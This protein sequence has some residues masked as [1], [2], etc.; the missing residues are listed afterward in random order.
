MRIP[1]GFSLGWMDGV[2]GDAY[3]ARL[4]SPAARARRTL[5]YARAN[6]Q[7]HCAA[8]YKDATVVALRLPGSAC[9]S[10]L[11]HVIVR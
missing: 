1:L 9:Y 2:E 6:Y 3:Y 7:R 8:Y 11:P 4:L 10:A 5:F